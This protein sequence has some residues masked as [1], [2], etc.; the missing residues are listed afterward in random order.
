MITYEKLVQLFE[1]ANK[2]FLKK[3]TNILLRDISE[4]TLCGALML[5]IYEIIR[6]NDDYAGYY[7]DVEYNRNLGHCE[8][9][10]RISENVN[11]NINCDLILHS[12]GNITRQDNLIA[13]EMKK[14]KRP[15]SEKREDKDRLRSLTR[16]PNNISEF[17]LNLPEYVCGYLLGVYCEVNYKKRIIKYQF[18]RNGRLDKHFQLIFDTEWTTL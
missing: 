15:P 7:V 13:L 16:T 5:E 17:E 9:K 4:R 14:A 18:Y 12:R 11:D 1:K 3:N 8:D 2:N 10:K 6:E